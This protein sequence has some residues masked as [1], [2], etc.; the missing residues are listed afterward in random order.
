MPKVDPE[1][2][3][4]LADYGMQKKKLDDGS[5]LWSGSELRDANGERVWFD[6]GYTEALY[7][8]IN[9]ARRKKHLALGLNEQGQTPEQE[10]NFKKRLEVS[11]KNKEK[12]AVILQAQEQLK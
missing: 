9:E 1:L 11:K 5:I 8:N 3:K 4:E 12:A 2:V 10:K 7:A 6:G